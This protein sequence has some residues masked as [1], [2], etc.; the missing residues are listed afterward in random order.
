MVR[1]IQK[2][3]YKMSKEFIMSIYYKVCIFLGMGA[4]LNLF[5]YLE[6]F[7]ELMNGDI[8]KKLFSLEFN[9]GYGAY[10]TVFN[11][12]LIVFILIFAINLGVLVYSL[13]G[14]KS[15]GLIAEAVFYNTIITF[16]IV[17]AH[18]A[19]YIQ[20]PTTVNGE[21]TNGI[22][23]TSFYVLADEVVKVFNFSYLLITVYLFY[24][25]FVIYR[26]MPEKTYIKSS[27]K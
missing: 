6:R 1:K 14:E 16:L 3:G 20:I 5:V 27:K 18:I 19:F 22:F 26:S 24:N 10:E 2:W 23:N 17:I 25:V 12:A 21:I 8:T 4:F 13:L 7:P 15:E 9:T 11:T